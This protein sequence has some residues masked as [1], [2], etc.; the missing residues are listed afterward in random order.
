MSSR[1]IEYYS[2]YI[3]KRIPYTFSGTWP[4]FEEVL[5]YP[6]KLE[7]IM[8]KF[9]CNKMLRGAIYQQYNELLI[10]N[11]VTD[12]EKQLLA[13][14]LLIIYDHYGS[15]PDIKYPRF[16]SFATDTEVWNYDD[17]KSLILLGYKAREYGVKNVMEFY[18]SVRSMCYK[19]GLNADDI[20]KNPSNIGYNEKYGMRVIDY[21]LAEDL[22]GLINI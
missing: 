20:L 2:D 15:I 10:Y 14:Q 16:E 17:D 12:K 1:K 5:N 6:E 13:P 19:Y 22:T 9:N 8:D 11:M 21:G 7:E 18:N 3:I 4:P